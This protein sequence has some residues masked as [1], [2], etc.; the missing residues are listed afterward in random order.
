MSRD[1]SAADYARAVAERT[2]WV[3]EAIHN[4]RLDGGDVSSEMDADNAE[5]ISGAIDA[6]ELVRR[7]R[8]RLGL[9]P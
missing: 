6:D 2:R 3:E 4:V 5:F 7:T 9:E 8:A 1:E